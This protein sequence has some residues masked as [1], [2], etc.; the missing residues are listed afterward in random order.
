MIRDSLMFIGKIDP[1]PEKES[2]FLWF[3]SSL[4]YIQSQ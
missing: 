2:L 1:A 3:F 4:S